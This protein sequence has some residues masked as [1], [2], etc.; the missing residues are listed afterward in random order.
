MEI[1]PNGHAVEMQIKRGDQTKQMYDLWRYSPP[2]SKPVGTEMG[3]LQ[4]TVTWYKIHYH[5][6]GEQAALWDIQNKESS[7]LTW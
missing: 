7:S 5:H 2:H 1:E 4:L 3:P 6:A